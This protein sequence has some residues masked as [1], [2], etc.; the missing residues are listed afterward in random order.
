MGHCHIAWRKTQLYIVQAVTCG[1]FDVFVRYAAAGI[2]GCQHFHAP[3]KLRQE[4]H[5]IGFVAGDLNVRTQGVQRISRKSQIMLTAKI[6]NG[7][8]ADVSIK[9]AMDVS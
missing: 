5:Q 3:V 8:C 1:I 9:V 2:K 7:L 6:E 4:T